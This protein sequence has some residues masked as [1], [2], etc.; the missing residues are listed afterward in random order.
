MTSHPHSPLMILI[1]YYVTSSNT[2]VLIIIIIVY[3]TLLPLSLFPFYPLT[4]ICSVLPIAPH[5]LIC[6]EVQGGCHQRYLEVLFLFPSPL[7]PSFHV[8]PPLFILRMLIPLQRYRMEELQTVLGGNKR[9][10]PLLCSLTSSFCSLLVTY[11]MIYH[12]HSILMLYK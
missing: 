5:D 1:A 3:I 11:C 12:F 8:P 7:L 6:P 9:F 2:L 10:T 4:S